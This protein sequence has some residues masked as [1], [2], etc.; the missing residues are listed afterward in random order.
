MANCRLIMD[1]A[2]VTPI[3]APRLTWRVDVCRLTSWYQLG[4]AYNQADGERL[5]YKQAR[6]LGLR[7]RLCDNWGREIMFACAKN[8]SILQRILSPLGV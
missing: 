7:C 2:P 4:V 1:R 3:V 5:L 6:L 8:P